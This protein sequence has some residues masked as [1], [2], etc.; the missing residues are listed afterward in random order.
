MRLDSLRTSQRLAIGFALVLVLGVAIAA[1]G[2]WR[3]S[4]TLRDMHIGD[5]MQLR[6]VRA[7][8]W[9][10]ATLLNVTRTLAMAK[11][12]A[13]AEFSAYLAPQIKATSAHISELQK[14]IE[15]DVDAQGKAALA[16]IAQI[17]SRY[18]AMRDTIFKQLKE[19]DPAAWQA[20]EQ[21][22]IPAAD[23]YVAALTRFQQQQQQL[24][25]QQT[26]ATESA[27]RRAQ[28]WL[29]GLALLSLAIGA[30]GAWLISRSITRPLHHA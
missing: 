28:A 10:A 6:A 11:A 2:W 12:G 3:L 19:Q 9:R 23:G 14:A 30:G 13:T 7:G 27:V 17:R 18:I 15:A 1:L 29:A 4:A 16:E 20:I 21:Q 25:D 5:S 24:A 8:E 26:A 22:L